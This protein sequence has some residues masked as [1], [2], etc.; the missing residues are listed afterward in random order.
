MKIQFPK[1]KPQVIR[2]L[3]YKGFY[4]KTFSDSLRHELNIYRLTWGKVR[5]CF[6]KLSVT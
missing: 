1:M 2:Y 4:N 3:K 6:V 5:H